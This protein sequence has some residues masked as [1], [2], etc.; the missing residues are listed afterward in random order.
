MN[1]LIRDIIDSIP[2]PSLS[3]AAGDMILL[4]DCYRPIPL[5]KNNFHRIV[6]AQTSR[7]AAF[8][9]GG[10]AEIISGADFSLHL[11]RTAVVY[12]HI[13]KTDISEFF[14]LIKIDRN[15][16]YTAE[17]FPES[18]F[19]FKLS[20]EPRHPSLRVGKKPFELSKAAAIV[21]RLAELHAAVRAISNLSRDDFILLDGTLQSDFPNENEFIKKLV[22]SASQSNITVTSLAKTT[23]LVTERGFSAVQSLS[24]LAPHNTW[25]YHPA[26]EPLSENQPE[27]FFVRLNRSSSFIF[28]FETFSSPEEAEKII[29]VIAKNSNDVMFPGYPDGLITADRFARISERERS[30]Y[31]GLFR[32]NLGKR[33]DRIKYSV[34]ST[35]AHDMLDQKNSDL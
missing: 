17:I 16:N 19:P 12:A 20:F 13:K 27:L 10:N 9:D 31:S 28:R 4:E 32:A 11:I 6:P 5:S 15:H 23:K 33:M 3:D 30:Y 34:S 8:V 24:L 26:A 14:C 29:T 18:R 21:R 22:E 35:S 25:F 2:V 7:N 1:S